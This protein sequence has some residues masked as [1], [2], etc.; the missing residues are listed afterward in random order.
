MIPIFLCRRCDDRGVERLAFHS[1]PC[2]PDD[3]QARDAL[4]TLQDWIENWPQD[5]LVPSQVLA[6]LYDSVI[7]SLA[8]LAHKR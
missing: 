2:L 7:R 1:G 3:A 6:P 8:Y 5:E 4:R